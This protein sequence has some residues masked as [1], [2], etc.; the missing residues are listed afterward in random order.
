MT[1]VGGPPAAGV[2][3]PDTRLHELL[4]ILVARHDHDVE[5]ALHALPREGPDDVVGLE[6]L[7]REDRDPVRLEELADAFH[8]RVEIGLQLVGELFPR[9]LVGRIPL[10]PEAEPRVVDP[11][12]VFGAMLVE[13]ALDEVDHSPRG[14]RVLAAC[15]GERPGD[16]GEE[17]AI[18]QRISVDEEQ[19]GPV[20]LGRPGSGWRA[21]EGRVGHET[22]LLRWLVGSHLGAL[23]LL[24]EA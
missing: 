14:R 22:S 8:A 4:E 10:V 24:R 3:Q 15:G 20:G 23:A 19:P 2:Q 6:A 9:R 7:E 11:A 17:R 5:A 13:Q 1:C 16:Q 21:G 18:D 12:E